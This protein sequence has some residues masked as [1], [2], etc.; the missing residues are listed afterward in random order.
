MQGATRT[1]RRHESVKNFK[2]LKFNLLNRDIF[3][4]NGNILDDESHEQVAGI[5]EASCIIIMYLIGDAWPATLCV[6]N[7][8]GPGQALVT[9]GLKVY[10]NVNL[11]IWIDEY[12][13]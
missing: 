12:Y 13:K 8:R 11:N 5:N 7:S 10:L 1:S 2:A 3:I 6:R 9:V 4:L